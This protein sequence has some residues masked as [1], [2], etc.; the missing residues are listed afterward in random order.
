[1]KN[2]T[3][4]IKHARAAIAAGKHI[5]MV[6]VEADVLADRCWRRKRARPAWSIPWPMAT[7]RH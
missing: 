6:N 7:S 4:G 2:P 3:V 1:L 5:V